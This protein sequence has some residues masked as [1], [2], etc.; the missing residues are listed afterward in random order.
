MLKL[1]VCLKQVP[2]VTEL[3]WDP[4]TGTLK[5]DAADGM[6][7][8]SCKS[9]LEAALQ[10]KDQRPA[11]ITTISMGPPMAEEVLREA[12][13]MGAD[14]GILLT[15]SRLAGADTLA[16]S[17]TLASAIR[18]HCPDADLVLCGSSSSDSDTAQVGPQLMEELGIPG[19]AYVR[20]IVILDRTI[21]MRRESDDFLETLEM[22]APG[23]VTVMAEGFSPRYA[24]LDGLQKAF[25]TGEIL[26]LSLDDLGLDPGS[27]G[28]SGSPTRIRNVYSTTARKQNLIWKGS[29]GKL[30]KNL[31][32]RFQ[33]TLS[34]AMAKDLK[35]HDHDPDPEDDT[36]EDSNA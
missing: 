24:S 33:D 8:P 35:T 26:R 6:M 29:P 19:V 25:E 31:F 13:A 10:I 12:I 21:R 3:P 32:D 17:F 2:M 20:E 36:L 9:A 11:H 22:E 15:D 16:T 27:V 14:S 30:A 5:R 28:V 34:G 18:M 23:L 7:N 1:I 4:E